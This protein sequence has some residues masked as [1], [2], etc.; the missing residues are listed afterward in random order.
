MANIEAVQSYK[1]PDGKIFLSKED[2]IAYT[3]RELYRERAEAYTTHRKI[4]GPNKTRTVNT[5][6]DYCAFEEV[7]GDLVDAGTPA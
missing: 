4:E 5:I 7:F 6:I 1:T 2:A 3:H